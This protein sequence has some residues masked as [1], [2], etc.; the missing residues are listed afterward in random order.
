MLEHMHPAVANRFMVLPAFRALQ[1]VEPFLKLPL[2]S[3]D[4][5]Q[6]VYLQI[7][8]AVEV[9]GHSANA[10]VLPGLV[11]QQAWSGKSEHLVDGKKRGAC[12][13]TLPLSMRRTATVVPGETS[14]LSRFETVCFIAS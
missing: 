12:T 3:A 14:G 7:R 6:L 1:F 13:H 8:K 9:D 10:F 11:H 4:D 5:D 2:S